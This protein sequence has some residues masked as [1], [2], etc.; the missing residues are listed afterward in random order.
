MDQVN[1]SVT[2]SEPMESEEFLDQIVTALPR[3]LIMPST[4]QKEPQLP[5]K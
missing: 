5:Q 1:N 2:L 3:F 4:I